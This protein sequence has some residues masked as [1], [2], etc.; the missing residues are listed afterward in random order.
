MKT[1]LALVAALA[2][3]VPAAAAPGDPLGAD[4]EARQQ[5]R[6]RDGVQSGAL[7]RGEAHRA[8]NDQRHVDRLQR[9]AR[10]DGTVTKKEARQIDRAQDRASRRLH[11]QKHDGQTRR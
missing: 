4:R 8:R 7:T 6:L 5:D 1:L 2:L 9:R 3:A 10:H 11:R